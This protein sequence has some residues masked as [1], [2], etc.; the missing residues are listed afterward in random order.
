MNITIG[1]NKYTP[2]QLMD[3]ID[4]LKAKRHFGG[5]S[6]ICY[7]LLNQ[8]VAYKTNKK[9][10]SIIIIGRRWFERVNGNTYHTAQ[11]FINGKC[12]HRT[13]FS[14]GYGD[15]FIW[16]AYK[17]LENKDYV[18]PEHQKHGATEPIWQ[19]CQR[20]DITFSYTVVDVSRKKDL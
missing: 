8:L 20:N 17:W 16:T 7:A 13:T 6:I 11:I 2:K 15:Q 19:Y 9:I 10:N 3:H 1:N 5:L 12:V 4:N 18:H 14:Y